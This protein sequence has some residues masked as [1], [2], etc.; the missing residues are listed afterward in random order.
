[1]GFVRPCGWAASWGCPK[2]AVE[3]MLEALLKRN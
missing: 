3:E 2:A 1:V